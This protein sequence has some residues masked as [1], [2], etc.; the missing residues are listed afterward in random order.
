MFEGCADE[1]T[2]RP[3]EGSYRSSCLG[4][5]IRWAVA[6][7]R[8]RPTARTAKRVITVGGVNVRRRCSRNRVCA[9]SRSVASA[10][11]A[12]RQLPTGRESMNR[13]IDSIFIRNVLRPSRTASS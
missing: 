7:P 6:K 5:V 3:Q 13:S 4:H 12:H 10:R 11:D 9:G 2:L 1:W 8:T